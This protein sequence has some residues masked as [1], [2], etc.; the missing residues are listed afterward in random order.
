MKKLYIL[1]ICALFMGLSSYAQPNRGQQQERIK[2]LKI[3]H[4]T[5]ALG[6]TP[7]EAQQFWPLYNAYEEKV[8]NIRKTERTEGRK[9]MSGGFD[10]MTDAQANALLDKFMALKQQEIDLNKDFVNSLKG[11]ISSKKILK[12]NR[13]EEGF[14]RRLLDEIRN[15]RKKN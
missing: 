6:L 9:A 7:E 8:E 1:L 15:R 11:V 12:L 5:N 14:K 2:A 13:A 3:A 4:I 10:A